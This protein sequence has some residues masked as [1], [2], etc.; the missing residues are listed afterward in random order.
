MDGYTAFYLAVKYD[1]V[2]AARILIELEVDTTI[3][4]AAGQTAFESAANCDRSF[5][6]KLDPNKHI[7]GTDALQIKGQKLCLIRRVFYLIREIYMQ[8][9]V[10]EIG[11]TSEEVETI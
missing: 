4:N 1:S 9:L 11:L 6:N 5:T 2:D 10:L 8:G 3:V 7:N